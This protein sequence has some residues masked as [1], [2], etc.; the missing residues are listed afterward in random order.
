[1]LKARR[2]FNPEAQDAEKGMQ[3]AIILDDTKSKKHTFQEEMK[4][5][6]EQCVVKNQSEKPA[7]ME[8]E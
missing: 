6:E 8:L 2:R 4:K 7:E 1:M 5:Q 3:M